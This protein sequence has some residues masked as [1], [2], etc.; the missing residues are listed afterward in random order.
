MSQQQQVNPRQ[1]QIIAAGIT[2]SNIVLAV[3]LIMLSTQ[4]SLP[5]I[6]ALPLPATIVGPIGIGLAASMVIVSFGL[7]RMIAGN[8]AKDIPI[9]QRVM[10]STIIAMA[11]CDAGSCFGF[12]LGFL[13]GELLWA[14][15]MMG[16]ATA[17]CI[18][19]F[20]TAGAFR[21]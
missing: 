2:S 8:Q 1:A 18:L 15:G 10:Q 5:E 19:H 16:I 11:I 7:K 6:S 14:I 13:T 9:G 3:V 4:G 20:P 12:V 17:G 21:E